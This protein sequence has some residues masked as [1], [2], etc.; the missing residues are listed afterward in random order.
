MCSPAQAP[1][2][3]GTA[4]SSPT[5]KGRALLRGTPKLQ[6]SHAAYL[7]QHPEVRTLLSDFLQALLFQQPQDPISFAAD[8][9]AHQR[10][11][12]SP[13][14]STGAASPLPSTPPGHPP[15]N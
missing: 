4:A 8:F 12:G 13:F 14:A 7:Q 3:S 1:P 15:D 6:L 11:I 10:P 9:F 2:L 5:G